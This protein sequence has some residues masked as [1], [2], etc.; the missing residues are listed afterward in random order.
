MTV[1]TTVMAGISVCQI[2]PIEAEE[3]TYTASVEEDTGTLHVEASAP[4]D[5]LPEDAQLVVSP[6]VNDGTN[7]L[8]EDTLNKLNEQAS[9]DKKV[10]DAFCAYDIQFEDN[11]AGVEPDNGYVSVS[12]KWDTA[13]KPDGVQDD[14]QVSIIHLTSDDKTENLTEE[15]DTDKNHGTVKMDDNDPEAVTEA[16]IMSNSFSVY[17]FVWQRDDISSVNV[18][19]MDESGNEIAN[20]NTADITQET[21]TD[22]LVQAIDGYTYAYAS[23][24]NVNVQSVNIEN[25]RLYFYDGTNWNQASSDDLYLTYT[26]NPT[27]EVTEPESTPETTEQ[28]EETEEPVVTPEATPE[29]EQN[30]EK[31]L[32]D[33]T[34]DGK[35]NVTVT[36]GDDAGLPEGTSLSVKQIDEDN[37]EYANAK[38]AVSTATGVDTDDLGMAALDIT[39]LDKDGNKVEPEDNSKVKV[40]ITAVDLPDTVN[41]I[42]IHHIT[43]NENSSSDTT[44]LSKIAGLFK[45]DDKDTAETVKK[46][47]TVTN[48]QAV[49]DFEVSSFSTF[50]ITWTTTKS[51]DT[52]D[53][54]Y[55]IASVTVRYVDENGLNLDTE[56]EF[57]TEEKDQWSQNENGIVDLSEWANNTDGTCRVKGYTYDHATLR[58]RDGQVITGLKA[59]KE[60]STLQARTGYDE[61]TGQY[62]Y[63]DV[64]GT[65]YRLYYTTDQ[66]IN[67]EDANANTWTEFT[68]YG[69]NTYANNSFVYLVYKKIEKPVTIHF[70]DTS[71]NAIK[72]S[73]G[74]DL[75]KV[76]DAADHT[77]EYDLAT[78]AS[79][80][81]PSGY[82]FSSD[83]LNSD[84]AGTNK[85]IVGDNKG[86]VTIGSVK[87]TYYRYL[88]Y[89]NKTVELARGDKKYNSVSD[90]VDIYITFSGSGIDPNDP[91][92]VTIHH[93]DRYGAKL[94]EDT[95]DTF[96]FTNNGASNISAFTN[97]WNGSSANSQSGA[98]YFQQKAASNVGTYQKAY[99]GTFNDENNLGTG[100]LFYKKDS[101]TGAWQTGTGAMADGGT[102]VTTEIKVNGQSGLYTDVYD[103]YSGKK[104]L[105]IHYVDED[106]NEIRTTGA[107]AADNGATFN[108]ALSPASINGYTYKEA[109]IGSYNGQLFTTITFN[110]ASDDTWTS[111]VKNGDEDVTVDP[112]PVNEVWLVYT[113]GVNSKKITLHYQY[114][115]KSGSYSDAYYGNDTNNKTVTVDVKSGTRNYLVTDPIKGSYV[116]NI[117]DGNVFRPA[118]E[119]ETG[120]QPLQFMSSHLAGADGPTVASVDLTSDG[121]LIY[122]TSMSGTAEPD[123]NSANPVSWTLSQPSGEQK[124]RSVSIRKDSNGYLY[125]IDSM[126]G[127]I[128]LNLVNDEADGGSADSHIGETYKG[129]LQNATTDV[130]YVVTVY[131][132]NRTDSDGT[133]TR[134]PRY[135]IEVT[136]SYPSTSTDVYQ[137]YIDG[138]SSDDKIWIEDDMKYTGLF[139][140]DASEHLKN[141]FNAA[142]DPNAV[143]E[144]HRLTV[145]DS[146]KDKIPTTIDGTTMPKEVN[147]EVVYRKISGEHWNLALNANERTWLDIE[148]DEGDD[149]WRK[150]KTH[151][152]YAKVTYTPKNAAETQT[153]YTTPLTVNYYGQLENGSFEDPSV[154]ESGNSAPD[155]GGDYSNGKYR[156]VGGVW[157]TTGPGESRNKSYAGKDIEIVNG[158]NH[159]T[160][161]SAYH[162]QATAAEQANSDGSWADDGDQFAELN[163]EN[164][165]ALYQDVIT[166][167][168][169]KINYWLSH[170]ARGSGEADR[171]AQN[172]H[173]DTMYV[174]IMP[175]KLAMTMGD[176][177]TELRTQ[178]ELQNF[179]STHGGFDTEVIKGPN[180]A[181]KE[182]ATLTYYDE[183]AGIMIYKVRSDEDGWHK[184]IVNNQYTAKGGLTRFFFAAAST[185]GDKGRGEVYTQYANDPPTMG[186]FIDNV[187]FNQSLPPTTG[188]NL[189]VTETFS[190]ITMEQLAG[191]ASNASYYSESGITAQTHPLQVT[192]TNT[193]T[194]NVSGGAT[195]PNDAL[196][197]AKLGFSM[198]YDNDG[199]LVLTPTAI[200]SD[201]LT[202]LLGSSVQKPGS[203]EIHQYPDGRI[204]IT[205]KFPD[206]LLQVGNDSTIDATYR[207]TA[208]DNLV[209]GENTSSSTDI[210]GMTKTTSQNAVAVI[211]GERTTESPSS[212]TA[213]SIN[214]LVSTGSDKTLNIVNVYSPNVHISV[215]KTFEGVT[216]TTVNEMMNGSGNSQDKPYSITITKTDDSNAVK[217][218][219]VDGGY[220]A[221]GITKDSSVSV[222]S[223]TGSDGS[224]TYK[225]TITDPSWSDATYNVQESNY[226]TSRNT[227]AKVTVN[228]N[229]VT[230]GSDQS[231][232]SGSPSVT[233]N[234]SD[235]A[236]I[237]FQATYSGRNEENKGVINLSV[238]GGVLPDTSM[239]SNPTTNL[240]VGQYT[241][242]TSE[243]TEE[244]S[245][246]ASSTSVK[247]YI[248]WTSTEVGLTSRNA[249]I[250]EINSIWGETNASDKASLNNTS[251]YTGDNAYVVSDGRTARMVNRE[252]A[253]LGSVNSTDT[254][255]K[256]Y[257]GHMSA[258][259]NSSFTDESEIRIE[260][261]YTPLIRIQKQ[262]SETTTENGNET[263]ERLNGAVFRLY[264][265]DGNSKQY[266]QSDGKWNASEDTAKTFTTSGN[267]ENKGIVDL[268][269][270]P[271]DGNTIY[272]LE[273]YKAPDG[274]NK[275]SDISFKVR[276]NGTVGLVNESGV[277]KSAS[278]TDKVQIT[279]IDPYYT[280]II[281][282]DPGFIL[283]ITGGKG[284]ALFAMMGMLL[285][286][287]AGVLYAKKKVNQNIKNIQ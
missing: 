54:N 94:T 90:P 82:S 190:G 283:P 267:G 179:I 275:I 46:N 246:P 25:G 238:I 92:Q 225:W 37:E 3:S 85:I 83:K 116:E 118:G 268:D 117:K 124:G 144:W 20:A 210:S 154:T 142:N 7:S 278:E 151:A 31:Q 98:S 39:L 145:D 23:I 242:K 19:Y 252:S 79:S 281:N 183:D 114:V 120:A 157:Q 181:S 51:T 221:D 276:T 158:K 63:K 192:L 161:N 219:K 243:T 237:N 88:K 251:F 27:E 256:F 184:V 67:K 245:E 70:L 280:I 38:K 164:A 254:W 270:L 260:N 228:E 71:G 173:F 187:G 207:Y 198:S 115:N 233:I 240:V 113:K 167:P 13:L 235:A 175:T 74:N 104:G 196:N 59:V 215:R 64:E 269:S 194:T 259:S 45:S 32:T 21:G 177:G 199:N 189:T 222:S 121:T 100:G 138:K 102:S 11:D 234:S 223:S 89:E 253:S 287:I 1:I 249:I 224:T 65:I 4:D 15:T 36:Y 86:K 26:V 188:F 261:E 61:S 241:L 178:K 155:A 53:Q 60:N 146:D 34:K 229:E 96:G 14:D 152:Y 163:A 2:V 97:R 153:L 213:G 208:N 12:M 6:I 176:N 255:D 57:T 143:V 108:P 76:I 129:T 244:G 43:E 282:D 248:V 127:D 169:E 218:L 81:V 227:L 263:H 128:P 44:L 168:N 99:I 10:I 106:G 264:K 56:K 211:D 24:D 69:T 40:S 247:K 156:E 22:A 277:D 204:V 206:Q 101:S 258:E 226:T 122:H 78:F 166:H 265:K 49:T 91:T 191:L 47:V 147:D 103:V 8:Y 18:H 9:K 125:L 66:T 55:R 5:V 140:L 205:W 220:Q 214:S 160:L 185:A 80:N 202:D 216:P 133:V 28:P 141:E 266:Y 186:N 195:T 50:T 132:F 134:I 201:G 284:I 273:E 212:T 95:T 68:D 119:G 72:D 236:N 131:Y 231:W 262:S 232:P 230:L 33:S 250:N 135:S 52:G 171:P 130:D 172:Y 30:T 84:N 136:N 271:I 16:S 29:P 105:T 17:A 62:T 110:E 139:R 73:D 123:D 150:G 41:S 209:E 274:Y 77:T 126:T 197:G 93:I 286:A 162:W 149:V 279:F 217:I 159:A 137:V 257:A 272:Y 180:D 48:G 165:G 182:E 58:S 174:V 239:N 148:A 109:H 107:N 87:G 42:D 193:R 75:T 200:A 35:Y 203:S 112:N 170:R 285:I 111:S